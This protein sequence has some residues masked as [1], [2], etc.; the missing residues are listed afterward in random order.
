ME[1]GAITTFSSGT[2]R[3]TLSLKSNETCFIIISELQK[4]RH[5]CISMAA[6]E[7]ILELFDSYWFK[8]AVLSKKSPLSSSSPA[9]TQ[10]T[11]PQPRRRGV[12][13][14]SFTDHQAT[15][16][17][18]TTTAATK[19]SSLW[20]EGGNR[21][22]VRDQSGHNVRPRIE[23]EIRELKGFMDLGFVFSEEDKGCSRL[24]SL[25]PGL[26]KMGRRSKEEEE[27]EEGS[28]KQRKMINPWSWSTG[29]TDMKQSLRF[30]AHSVASLSFQRQH[31]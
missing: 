13:I 10:N 15:V 7:Q 5:I 6:A 17:A 26:Q 3:H 25:I 8:T 11:F 24:V 20:E 30:W 31:N 18:S 22:R 14:R 16:A 28:V 2:I 12:A 1:S 9:S 29:E 19:S 23:L 4:P 21:K 27:E